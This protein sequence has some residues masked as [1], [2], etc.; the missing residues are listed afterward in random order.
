MN[1][2]KAEKTEKSAMLLEFSVDKET[3]DKAVSKVYRQQVGK[4]NVPGFRKGK[5]PRSVIERMY[6]KGIFWEDAANEVLPEAYE[7]ALAES[8]VKPVGRA[9]FDILSID[10]NGIVFSANVPVKPAVEIEGYKG[11]ASGNKFVAEGLPLNTFLMPKY[12]GVDKSNGLPMWYKDITDANGQV[13]GTTMTSEYS[14]ATEYLCDDPTPKLYGGFGTSFS[15]YN[16]DISAAFTYSLGG[17]TYD[18]GYASYMSPPGGS[19][20]SNIHKDALKAWTPENKNSDIPRFV[21]QDQNINASS[22]RFLVPASYLNFQNAQIGYTFSPKVTDKMHISRLRL[23]V[24]CDKNRD[25]S[26]SH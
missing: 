13:I 18:S 7:A 6:G 16:F 5:A 12:A 24:A 20:G 1:L 11:Y 14:E 15:F 9:E 25:C 3:F 19:V 22:D 4:I 17:L 2:I 23:Y 26:Y 8:G 10:E 21:Y